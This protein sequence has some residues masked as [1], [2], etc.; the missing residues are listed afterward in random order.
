M[1]YSNEMLIAL[2]N[3]VHPFKLSCCAIFSFEFK[4]QKRENIKKETE[5]VL[6]SKYKFKSRIARDKNGEKRQ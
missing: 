2:F 3:F 1:K 4:K 5:F 6:L